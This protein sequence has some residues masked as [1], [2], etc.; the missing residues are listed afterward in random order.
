MMKIF[1]VLIFCIQML[2]LSAKPFYVIIHGT[3]CRP[4]SWHMP[5]GDFYDA[6]V[7]ATDSISVSFFIWSGNN[8]H[9]DRIKAAQQLVEHLAICVPPNAE[10]TI[11]AHSHGANVAILASHIMEC[12]KN[13]YIIHHFYALGTPVSTV[14]YF[15]N[16]H[17]IR[18]FYNIFSFSDMVQPVFGM[19]KREFPPHE[20]ISNLCITING[21]EPSHSELHSPLVASW[22]PHLPHTLQSFN[23]KP[24]IIHFYTDKPPIYQ[25]DELRS[26]RQQRDMIMLLNFKRK[27]LREEIRRKMIAC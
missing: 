27:I 3:W 15:P 8:N 26:V 23:T 12:Q 22:L 5:G 25:I 20:R 19:F 1:M 6:L 4:F 10:L 7:H 9:Q 13:P 11:I 16:M 24:G 17:I 2:A 18:S 21:K 14:S